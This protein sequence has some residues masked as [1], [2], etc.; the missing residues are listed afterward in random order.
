V[1]IYTASEDLSFLQPSWGNHGGPLTIQPGTAA[2]SAGLVRWSLPMS[3]QAMTS[4][5][6]MVNAN[7]PSTGFL[8]AQAIDLPFSGWTAFAWTGADMTKDNPGEIILAKAGA[9]DQRYGVNGA[10]TLAGVSGGAVQG[11]LLYTG[12][13]PLGSTTPAG[14]PRALYAADT[15][16]TGGLANTASASCM[17]E[18]V[19]AW[20]D[21]TGPAALDHAGNLFVIMPSLAG[22]T[23]EARAFPAASIVSGKP[24]TNGVTLF[25]MPGTGLPLAAVDPSATADGILVFQPD[26][27]SFNAL[28]P[29]AQ[30]YTATGGTVQAVGMPA[31]FLK[32][33]T[34][35]TSVLLFTDDKMRL[36][37][38]VADSTNKKTTF[39]VIDRVMI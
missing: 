1:A 24:A 4:M 25:T 37:A 2:G 9:V 17:P 11:R 38:G 8:G 12:L 15:C 16:A 27:T 7:I 21:S 29:I 36:W 33:A 13:S 35:K 14:Q 30:H 34:P 5:G 3:G 22:G 39:V 28:D 20:G 6:T 10:G 32:L 31:G 26:D 18:E 19:S 23:Q